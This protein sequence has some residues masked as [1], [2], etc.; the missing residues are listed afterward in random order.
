MKNYKLQI[1][2]GIIC[3]VLGFMISVQ[4]RTVKRGIGTV[5][6]YKAREL[7]A[8]LKKVKEERDTLLSIKNE[9]ER[10]IR[11]YEEN[12]SR[13]SSTAKLLKDELDRV[14]VL[15]GLE[16]VE[17]PGVT[18]V[19]DDLKYGEQ[20]NE[21]L[22]TPEILLLVL[23][24]LNAAGTEAVSINEQRVVATT[25]IRYISEIHTNINTIKF[26]APYTFKAIGDPQSLERALRLRWGVVENLERQGISVVITQSPNI[27]ISKFNGIIERKHSKVVKEGA[28]Q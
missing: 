3:L 21:A 24:E 10:K 14:R 8:Q 11:E 2:I 12:A 5:S 23:N 27:V 18:V 7:A 15:A 13:G 1:A 20:N 9:N 28:S 26:T 16:D 6:E 22:I 25:E 17:G 19:L 4:L